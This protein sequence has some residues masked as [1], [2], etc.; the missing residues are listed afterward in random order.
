MKTRKLVFFIIL[1]L[2]MITAVSASNETSD[3]IVKSNDLN[4]D[5]TL[6]SG[7]NTQ[8][9]PSL[10]E[11]TEENDVIL[12]N[13]GT[14]KIN[15]LK[16]TKN[17]TFQGN[18]NPN[19]IIFDG[20]E[21]SSIIL[22]RDK[23]VHAT[24]KNITFINGYTSNFGGAIS[25]ETG[26][27]YV[28]NCIFKHNTAVGNTNAGAISNYGTM[29]DRAYL[30]VN[31]SLFID[32]YAEHDGGAVTTCYASSDILNSIFVNN[33]AGRDGGAI[34]VSVY[35]YCNTEDC[36]F[37]YNHA[38]E[39]GGAFYSWACTSKINRCIFMNNTGG[40]NGGAVMI[41]GNMTL[42]NSIIVNNTGEETGGSFFIRHPM[43]KDK[44]WININN[45]LITNNSSPYGKEVYI[46]WNDTRY[47]YTNFNNNDWGD[48]N[49]NDPS[50]IDPDKVTSR[51]KVTKTIKSDLLNTLSLDPLNK[52]S[53][54]LRKYYPPGFFGE[55]EV[56]E[57][58]D[59]DDNVKPSKEK[60]KENPISN[61]TEKVEKKIDEKINEKI[62]VNTNTNANNA[63]KPLRQAV[64]TN[65]TETTAQNSNSE[66]KDTV[67]NGNVG[68][69][70]KKASYIEKTNSTGSVSKSSN[71]KYYFLIL[72]PVLAFLIGF[73][74]RKRYI[75]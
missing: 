67:S 34:R 22:V 24:F 55:E 58:P 64:I 2:L 26:N 38:G 72:I 47:L 41:S 61:N 69:N 29:E 30:L 5:V 17:I 44:T 48:E 60:P 11:N 4:D 54:L 12:I 28:D 32:N 49:P 56:P 42:T 63:I 52:Y 31:N 62:N 23:N 19:D 65:T 1:L 73:I 66:S 36:I 9:I 35:G 46:L 14:Y 71:S 59:S 8:E 3:E 16:I 10:V 70:N 15:N 7:E 74:G 75:E 27:V 50:V 18:G 39:W 33:S 53:N 21:K 57:V 13:P 20:Q 51:S 40:T 68:N 43:Y 6:E 37:M 45:N 25:M